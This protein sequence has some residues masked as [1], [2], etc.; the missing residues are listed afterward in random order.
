MRKAVSLLKENWLIV[1]VICV[2]GGLSIFRWNASTQ[3][4]V[5]I[6]KPTQP[7]DSQTTGE[8]EGE[9][10]PHPHAPVHDHTHPHDTEPHVEDVETEHQSP[11][12]DT[13]DWRND[14]SVESPAPKPDP[15]KD[16]GT[17]HASTDPSTDSDGDAALYPPPDWPSTEDPVL[18]AEYFHAQ[19]INQFGDIPEVHI[20]GERER[21]RALGIPATLDER[22]DFLKAQYA[23]WPNERTLRALESLQK[24]GLK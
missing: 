2:I 6:Y 11:Q 7:N 19:L 16:V 17:P 23:L 18:L 14:R 20:I 24:E 12:R 1:I 3:K 9:T 13:Y 15:W 5:T 8:Q 10:H 21:K 22:I 4:P